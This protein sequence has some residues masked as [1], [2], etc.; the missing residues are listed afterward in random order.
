MVDFMER[1]AWEQNR[2]CHMFLTTLTD[3]HPFSSALTDFCQK[4]LFYYRCSS[5]FVVLHDSTTEI[6]DSCQKH[7]SSIRGHR[8]VQFCT[9]VQ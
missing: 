6:M 1:E 7:W 4:H 2:R 9:L 8:I 3:S 5:V